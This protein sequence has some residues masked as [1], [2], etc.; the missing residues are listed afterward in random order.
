MLIGDELAGAAGNGFCPGGGI[1]VYDITGPLENAPV[2]VGAFFIP[3]VRPAGTGG[4][5]GWASPAPRTSSSPSPARPC[6]RSPGTTPASAILDYS[7]LGTLNGAGAQVGVANTSVTPGITQVGYSYF[8][9]SNLWSA[10]VYEVDRRRRLLHLR[11]RHPPRPRRVA[12]HPRGRRQRVRGGPRH[13][14]VADRGAR[15]RGG[16]SRGDDARG[17]RHPVL[18]APALGRNPPA[19]ELVESQQASP[20]HG[21]PPHSPD[22]D[23]AGAASTSTDQSRNGPRSLGPRGRFVS[24]I[25]PSRSRP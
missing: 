10:K 7:G 9:N 19:D 16:P 2:K 1:H 21:P 14:A 15:A 4:A 12:L 22:H 8:E 5:N 11:R 20:R 18:P 6:S 17:W 3:D 23:G 24:L 25:A 13:L